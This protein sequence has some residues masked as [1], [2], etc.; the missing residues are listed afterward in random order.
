ARGKLAYSGRSGTGGGD[1]SDL[2]R[3]ARNRPRTRRGD[4]ARAPAPVPR[5]RRYR[6]RDPA[7]RRLGG[8][9]AR[10]RYPGGPPAL[11]RSVRTRGAGGVVAADQPGGRRD[12]WAQRGGPGGR[13]GTRG[14]PAHREH[15]RPAAVGWAL[16]GT[17]SA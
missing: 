3:P 11:G 10:C 8:V 14:A 12:R 16:L 6:G 9:S 15:D 1:E 4:T 17:R 2:A 5:P 13:V 7:G